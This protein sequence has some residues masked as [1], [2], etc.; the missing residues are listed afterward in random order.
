MGE[1]AHVVEE[2]HG[3]D[4]RAEPLA[5]PRPR[6]GRLCQGHNPGGTFHQLLYN[7]STLM[8]RILYPNRRL[9]GANIY[10]IN[11][12]KKEHFRI[13]ICERSKYLPFVQSPWLGRGG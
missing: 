10:L 12:L 5:L 2:E 11:D 8:L 9:I 4:L 13:N 3:E 7:G 6:L 1:G